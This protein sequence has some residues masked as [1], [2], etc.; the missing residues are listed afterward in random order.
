MRSRIRNISEGRR[1]TSS[2]IPPLVLSFLLPQSPVV[3]G[4]T[5]SSISHHVALLASS[6]TIFLIAVALVLATVVVVGVVCQWQTRRKHARSS[7]APKGSVGREGRGASGSGGGR[8]GG[9]G[10]VEGEGQTWQVTGSK[11]KKSSSTISFPTAEKLNMVVNGVH[12]QPGG[13]I[14]D[15]DLQTTTSQMTGQIDRH[16]V[17]SK[18]LPNL[19]FAPTREGKL[20]RKRQ[21]R[22][23][24][25]VRAIYTLQASLDKNRNK[26]GEHETVGIEGEGGRGGEN[27]V[28]SG[29][30]IKTLP[31]KIER[32]EDKVQ[33]RLVKKTPVLVRV[34]PLTG[35][36]DI[37][38][39]STASDLKPEDIATVL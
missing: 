30:I 9:C 11:L 39:H 4:V 8:G 26:G 36:L 38:R 19:F 1:G 16:P 15:N 37:S 22:K 31:K 18:S 3:S 21:L 20:C 35:E 2:P 13:G 24:V 33:I 17:L 7:L 25:T 12:Q 23:N 29:E 6:V 14:L 27:K 34:Q 32:E 5:T 28:G 10:G